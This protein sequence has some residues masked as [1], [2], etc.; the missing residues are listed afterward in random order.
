MHMKARKESKVA[1]YIL[2][3]EELKNHTLNEMRI[4]KKPTMAGSYSAIIRLLC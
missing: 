1:T 3:N 4:V 2:L